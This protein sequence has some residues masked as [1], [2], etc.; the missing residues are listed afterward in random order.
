MDIRDQLSKY[1]SGQMQDHEKEA[2]EKELDYFKAMNDYIADELDLDLD[3]GL[4]DLSGLH[5]NKKVNKKLRRNIYLSVISVTVI[6]LA[7]IYIV[8]PVMDKV[9]YDPSE[10]SIGDYYNNLS[11]DMRV[12]ASLK[13]PSSEMNH[14]IVERKGFAAYDIYLSFVNSFDRTRKE[15]RIEMKRGQVVD[16]FSQR[17]YNNLFMPSEFDN[18]D[19][20]SDWQI[21]ELKKMHGNQYGSVFLYFD[22]KSMEE[23]AK[24]HDANVPIKWI[25]VINESERLGFS[26]NDNISYGDGPSH[27]DYPYF[28][29]NDYREEIVKEANRIGSE[30]DGYEKALASY[31]EK[32]FMTLLT[33]VSDRQDI[34]KKFGYQI[35]VEKSK[36]YLSEHGIKSNGILVYGRVEDLIKYIEDKELKL[37][38][39]VDVKASMFSHSR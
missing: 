8:S 28:D 24:L 37:A 33:Y 14:A 6:F 16:Q 25:S 39:I 31:Y 19:D 7:L 38:D 13:F 10:V 20:I 26:V 34:L 29:L 3:K 22:A 21:K 9:F 12:I 23:V 35:D 15:S 2:F 5:I 32:H 17:P 18:I 27:D 4:P 11:F 36:A 1:K 30:N